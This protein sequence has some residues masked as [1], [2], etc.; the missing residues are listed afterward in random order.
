MKGLSPERFRAAGALTVQRWACL[1]RTLADP[2]RLRMVRLLERTSGPGLRV[3]DL[4]E[5]LKL[6]QSTVS[7]H[8]KSLVDGGVVDGRRA[9]TAMLYN[10]GGSAPQN[11]IRRLRLPAGDALLHD[12]Q[13]PSDA[14][15]LAQALERRQERAPDFFVA[16]APQ[17]DAIR[18]QW[19]GETFHLQA[20]L[21]LL[22]PSWT[23]GDLGAGTGAMFALTAPYVKKIIAVESSPA[24]RHAARRRVRALKLHNVELLSGRIE[25]LPVP[26]KTLDVALA[27][28]VL[29]HIADIPR[30][31]A[32]ICRAIK[33][34]G[35]LLIV[36][37][38]PHQV[39]VFREKMGHRWMGFEPSWLQEQ[40]AA[41]GL[42]GARWHT[43]PARKSRWR[44]NRVAVPDLFVM[45][46]ER[47]ACR[48]STRTQ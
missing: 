42:A 30:A 39:D 20:M 45:R 34:G 41:A 11:V 32:R 6:P 16:A 33:P 2:T 18:S 19:F 46:A 1:L 44:E 29:H 15:R 35:L 26:P 9:G 27:I 23:L 38:L 48:D 40:L 37:L 24:M 12:D 43:L 8:I 17:W 14:R 13:L 21:A 22:N 31:L 5:A 10:L 25:N 3:G 36:D 4:S 7:R 28:L 47:P